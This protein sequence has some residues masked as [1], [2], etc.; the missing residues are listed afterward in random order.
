ML[1]ARAGHSQACLSW[2]GSATTEA[3][4]RMGEG[5]GFASLAMTVGVREMASLCS[6]QPS[7]SWRGSAM[8]EAISCMGGGD[9]FASLAMTVGVR[10]MASL[11]SP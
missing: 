10:E 5:D 8:T 7:L 3:I 1:F 4:S 11:C 9:G 2:R 6:R